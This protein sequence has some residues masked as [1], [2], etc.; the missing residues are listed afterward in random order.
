MSM[1][2]TALESRLRDDNEAF[3]GEILPIRGGSLRIV[4]NMESSL[5]VPTATS[6]RTVPVKLLEEN[7]RVINEHVAFLKQSKVSFTHLIAWALIQALKSSPA[8]QAVFERADGGPHRRLCPT[9]N[10]GVA[11]DVEKRDGSRTLM[12]PNIKAV[13]R[14][15]FSE[16]RR[17][18]DDTIHK[19]R[20][21]TIDPSDF[22]GTTVTLTNP[23]TVGTTASL[24]RL[25][26]GQAAIIGTGS[27]GYPP[28]Y[29]AWSPQVL[30]GMGLSQVMTISCTYDHRIIQGAESG[31]FLSRVQELLV[32]Q[33]GFYEGIFEDL[34]I[35]RRPL[36]WAPDQSPSP[37][38]ASGAVHDVQK[39]VGV[40]QLINMYRVRGHLIASL[41]PLGDQPLYHPELDPGNYGLTLW[42]LDREFLTGGL[43]GLE[44]GTLRQILDVLQQTYCRR[45]GV[46]YR[47][48]QDVTEKAWLVDRLEPA[49]NRKPHD[50]ATRLL[51][52]RRLLEAE[53]FERYLHARFVGHKRFGLE[54]GETTIPV[55]ARIL[56][57]AANSDVPEAVI[58]MAHRGRLNV[59]ANITGKPYAEIF[60][61]F[62]E[63]KDPLATQGSG[64]VKYHLGS[65]GVF[66]SIE[67][68]EIF[69]SVAPNPSHLEWVN[70]V[71]EGITRAKQDRRGDG[72]HSQV[73]PILI[74][75]DAAFAGQGVVWET[76]NL[77]QLHG[78][79]TGGTIHL[80]INNQIGFTTTPE[81]SR[82]SPYATDLARA[83][84]APIF[85]VNGDDPDSAI[86]VA[87]LAYA[88][89]SQFK[90]DVV[91]D[92]LC[93]RRHGHNEGDEPSYTQPILY[94]HIAE[95]PS[96]LSLY[97]EE[98]IREGEL[99]AADYQ[100]L[101]QEF[102]QRL[103]AAYEES[104]KGNLRFEPDIP[105]AVSEEELREYQPAGGTEIPI[106]TLQEVARALTRLPEGFTLHPK[107]RPFMAKREELLRGDAEID[108]AFAEALAFG[109]LV[110]EG[111]PVRLSGQDSARG[112]F[113]QR[114]TVLC[115][116]ET[117]S[118]Y[119]P[120]QHV[121]P[122]QAQFTVYDSS[123]SEAGVLGFEFGY[124][125]ADPLSL[126]IWEAQFG[127]FA[128]GAQVIIDNFIASSESKW[129]QPCD[130]VMLLPHGY[131][132][133]GPEHSSARLERFLG[134]CAENNI[135]VCV[136]STAAQYFHLLRRQVRDAKRVPLVVMTPK[137]LLRHPRTVSLPAEF[138]GGGF[139]EVLDDP[140]AANRDSVR[141][142]L[143]CCGKIYYDLL[144]E[145]ERRKDFGTAIIRLEQLYPYPEWQI[146]NLLGGYNRL[147]EVR[148][149]QEEPQNMGAWPYLR[150]RVARSL[151]FGRAVKF[152][153]RPE[154][155]SP[156]SGSLKQ[157]KRE[158]AAIV[159]SAFSD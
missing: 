111:T 14:M 18:Y 147:S 48:I 69:V 65:S 22:Q 127:D 130:L 5:S 73:I 76:V 68:K 39:Q 126:V 1:E 54:G 52:L 128:N 149:V 71:V 20:S 38:A 70:P 97:S 154:S 45:I 7:R 53:T 63:N 35:P 141:R 29:L 89:R 72:S 62:E 120:L 115:D 158:Q 132:G 30:S 133:Q 83:V 106:E 86:R 92:I 109:S 82:S 6:Y 57:E 146:A 138:T 21:G 84:Q 157:H 41:D 79:R 12:V 19:T 114:H 17:A 159:H 8:F 131:E 85:H 156:S 94:R 134:I 40:L 67:G 75:G 10:L 61:E 122:D 98:L 37:F 108:W 34:K 102:Q 121:H 88:Y 125:S 2:D 95:K 23:G 136:P 9:V 59:L 124:S 152:I 11:V 36:S 96:V 64:D 100:N 47:H 153:A 151:P 155:A 27:I 119:T 26:Q 42:D 66:R 77:S 55:L 32:G 142:V 105:L 91:V 103:D 87:R 25:M 123:L 148:W 44:R 58:G 99:T 3:A 16:F 145:Q 93:Y 56:A 104:R 140:Q 78:Y 33:D 31:L 101:R 50:R 137:S 143:M 46:E 150:H 60:A 80:I 139:H 110:H 112:T 116:L 4:E 90:K 74:H 117:G 118:K 24:P 49:D 113:S 28:E 81:E 144:A 43:G 51:T 129:Q 13:D 15:S 107:L 135:R